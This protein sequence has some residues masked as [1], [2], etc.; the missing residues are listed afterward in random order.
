MPSAGSGDAIFLMPAR[1]RAHPSSTIATRFTSSA[2][3]FHRDSIDIF[4]FGAFGQW[5]HEGHHATSHSNGRQH[6]PKWPPFM[7]H[8]DFRYIIALSHLN[9]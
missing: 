4:N 2:A 3:V 7:K 9:A 1:E 6:Q 5:R 8:L